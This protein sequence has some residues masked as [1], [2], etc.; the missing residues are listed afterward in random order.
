[1]DEPEAVNYLLSN[2]PEWR[3]VYHPFD[4]HWAA[5]TIIAVDLSK[6][7]GLD[8][9]ADSIWV[10]SG[11][12]GLGMVF[13]G[14]SMGENVRTPE[15]DEK[16]KKLEKKLVEL[17]L[18]ET[19]KLEVLCSSTYP[20][21]LNEPMRM[22]LLPHDGRGPGDGIMAAFAYWRPGGEYDRRQRKER[23]ARQEMDRAKA[24]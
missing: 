14:N 7:C 6:D 16:L 4:N 19:P 21:H 24:R 10:G 22:V 12:L 11:H 1:M 5:M 18:V 2:Y 8:V 17:K 15:D 23:K 3:K 13:T 9:Y 20:P